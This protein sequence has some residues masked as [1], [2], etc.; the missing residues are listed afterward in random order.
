[1]TDAHQGEV[2]AIMKTKAKV[3]SLKKIFQAKI[4]N[5]KVDAC[6]QIHFL[7]DELNLARD[8]NWCLWEEF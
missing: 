5:L 6:N 4:K 8:K 3:A 2:Q 1:M 7:W